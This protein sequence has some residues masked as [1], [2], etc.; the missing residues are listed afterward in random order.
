MLR[1][2]QDSLHMSPVTPTLL[3]SDPVEAVGP[4]VISSDVSEPAVVA[5]PPTMTEPIE[6]SEDGEDG[7]VPAVA[8]STKRPK[9]D[10][11]QFI[12]PGG[13]STPAKALPSRPMPDMIPFDYEAESSKKPSMPSA[14]APLN[15][16]KQ[17]KHRNFNPYADIQEPD[18]ASV[19]S[20]S[21]M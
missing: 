14:S 3:P 4:S 7:E 16:K 5:A 18:E 15:K 21:F 20:F 12:K 9:L 17:N 1:S 6:N 19:F 13:S 11:L 10:L 2:I 8:S